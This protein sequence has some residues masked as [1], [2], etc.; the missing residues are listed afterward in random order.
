MTA[1]GKLMLGA[2]L[3]SFLVQRNF[4]ST[5]I[6]RQGAHI[7]SSV[8]IQ[9]AVAYGETD[10]ALCREPV[11]NEEDRLQEPQNAV[12]VTETFPDGTSEPESEAFEPAAEHRAQS[13]S[14]LS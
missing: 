5:T 6:D 7:S 13:M 12:T 11:S 9:L 3:G 8:W 14:S 4:K 2:I 1:S 10:R